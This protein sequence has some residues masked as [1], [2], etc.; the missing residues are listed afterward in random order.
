MAGQALELGAMDEAT[1]QSLGEAVRLLWLASRKVPVPPTLVLPT[2]LTTPGPEGEERLPWD[3]ELRISRAFDAAGGRGAAI[4]ALVEGDPRGE[5]ISVPT[6]REL[7]RRVPQVWRD[8]EASPDTVTLIAFH[9]PPKAVGLARLAGG[10]VEAEEGSAPVEESVWRAAAERWSALGE[11]LGSDLQ[12]GWAWVEGEVL[13]TS[14][15]PLEA[16]SEPV[17]LPQRG[18]PWSE[19]NA[20]LQAAAEADLK[21]SDGRVFGSMCTAP[22]PEALRAASLF[23]EANLGNPGLCPGTAELE[24]EVIGMLAGLLHGRGVYGQMVS[25]ST[26]GNIT[27]LWIAR[28]ATGRREVL[29]PKSAHFSIEKA[30]DLLDMRPVVVELDAGYRMDV[31]DLRSKL[32]D[33]TAAVVAFAGTTELGVVDPIPEIAEA[34]GDDAHLHVDAAYGGFVLP[35]MEDL[36]R[37]IPHFDFRVPRVSSITMD[38]DKMGMAPI[39]SSALLVR[40][41]EYVREILHTSPYL[42][43][44]EHTAILGTRASSGVAGTYASLMTLGREGFVEIVARTLEI[45]EFIAAGVKELGLELAVE[46]ETSIVG[47]LVRDPKAVR[48]AM[49]EKGW[50]VSLSRYPPCLRLVVMPHVTRGRAEEFLSDLEATCRDLGEL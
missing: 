11:A 6:K 1:A 36:G 50:I 39:P 24:E 43:K 5:A 44:L 40:D 17:A 38:G 18:L 2:P 27:A 34:C 46:P 12:V 26:E 8:L 10:A 20:R 21:L 13:V 16:A 35:F 3:L 28:N 19:V 15:R 37:E 42:T 14:V 22:L 31:A 45:T 9:P 41:R 48:E 32:S 7:L 49:A 47:V 29:F 30:C 23:P 4:S 25:G 33:D